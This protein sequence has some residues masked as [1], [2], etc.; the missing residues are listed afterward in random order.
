MLING[1]IK[2]FF[3]GKRGLRQGDSLS[4]LLFTLV[5]QVMS[6][7]IEKAAS[8][9]ELSGFQVTNQGTAVT[10]LQFADDSLFFLDANTAETQMLQNLLISFEMCSGL[11]VNFAKSSVYAVGNQVNSQEYAGIL[12]CKVGKL[13]DAYLGLPLGASSRKKDLWDPVITRI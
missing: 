10:L 2:G 12:K 6:R 9:N 3:R 11:Q 7:M 5:M 1:E 4:P 8:H 13:P